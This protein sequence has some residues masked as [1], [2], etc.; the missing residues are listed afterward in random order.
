MEIKTQDLIQAVDR[1]LDQ[2]V[3]KHSGKIDELAAKFQEFEQNALT[4]IK[5]YGSGAPRSPGSII[6]AHERIQGLRDGIKHT[7][8]VSLGELNVKALTSEQGSTASPAE[9]VDVLP[10]QASG[11]WGVGRRPLRLLDVIPRI[12]TSSNSVRYTKLTGF[13]NSAA[14]QSGEGAAKAEQTLTPETVDAPI[15]TVAVFTKVSKQVLEDAPFLEA[16]LNNLFRFNLLDR[17]EAQ[18]IAGD[19][20]G[21][22]ISGLET[23][24][25]AITGSSGVAQP[26]QIGTAISDMQSD[27]YPV[28]YL[29]VNPGDFQTWRAE[30]SSSDNLYVSGSWAQP[31][32]P[33]LWNTPAVLSPSLASGKVILASNQ[34]HAMLDRQDVAIEIFEQD[35]DN[36]QKNLLTLRAELRAG[37][38]VM[39]GEAVRTLTLV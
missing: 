30:R 24:G 3:E 32:P 4:S 33:V 15:A 12:Q 21:F 23:E 17:L 38:A 5:G 34:S 39:D 22:N 18:L 35:Q 11:L 16:A 25:K 26:D 37:L 13:S 20:T 28:S 14:V 7:G 9:G 19:G 27:G 10:S 6:V 36:I 31:N 29:V 8:R 2:A 1:S